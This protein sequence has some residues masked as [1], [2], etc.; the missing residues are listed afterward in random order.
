MV[1]WNRDLLQELG[2]SLKKEEKAYT[3]ALDFL[4]NLGNSVKFVYTKCVVHILSKIDIRVK[5]SQVLPSTYLITKKMRIEIR[6]QI[7]NVLYITEEIAKNGNIS[8]PIKTCTGFSNSQKKAA[9]IASAVNVCL[10]SKELYEQLFASELPEKERCDI[11]LT[12]KEY[13][14]SYYRFFT[15]PKIECH[16]ED[17]IAIEDC[18]DDDDDDDISIDTL[19]KQ[20]EVNRIFYII[21]N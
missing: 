17:T 9:F 20:T 18:N 12:G 4:T 3:K 19:R 5:Q 15:H 21:N 8:R 7:F 11:I 10:N 1:T 6:N 13:A 16:I 2:N 14:E